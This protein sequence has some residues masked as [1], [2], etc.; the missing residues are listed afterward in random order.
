MPLEYGQT[1]WDD[2]SKEELLLEV[3]RLYSATVSLYSSLKMCADMSRGDPYFTDRRSRGYK[4]LSKGEQAMLAAQRSY[5]PGEVYSCYFRYA[6]DLLFSGVGDGWLI[7]STGRLGAISPEHAA[8]Y[9]GSEASV[10][11][12]YGMT[13]VIRKI[14]WQDLEPKT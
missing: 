5:Q 10:S 13:G 6:D 11:G 4:A 14:T 9:D 3:K 8:Q 7:D 1:P 12:M 2:L